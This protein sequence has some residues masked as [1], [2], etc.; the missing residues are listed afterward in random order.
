SARPGNRASP[1]KTSQPPDPPR[2]CSS[3]RSARHAVPARRG[4]SSSP[5]AEIPRAAASSAPAGE[6][7]AGELGA[8]GEG[9]DLLVAH[10]AGGPA[11]AAVGVDVELLG[12][13]DLE[14]LADAG[15]DVFRRVLVE[16]LDVDHAGAELAAVAVLLP[17]RQLAQLAAGELEHELVGAGLE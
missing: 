14:H 2:Q 11:E 9:A 12:R 15:G 7:G 4:L 13:A 3:P 5:P 6:L 10:V 1:S 8:G 16:A 17:Q